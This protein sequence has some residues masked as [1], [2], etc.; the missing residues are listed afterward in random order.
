MLLRD[1]YETHRGARASSRFE[2]LAAPLEALMAD[3]RIEQV[4]ERLRAIDAR[5]TSAR[6][7]DAE[8]LAMIANDAIAVE[9]ML[10]ALA[11]EVVGR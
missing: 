11:R 2:E 5:E 1:V 4:R 8:A 6:I 9:E 3:P 7:G 10:R